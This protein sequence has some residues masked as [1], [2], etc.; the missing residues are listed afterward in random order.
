MLTM[1]PVVI[2]ISLIGNIDPNS[3]TDVIFRHG[4]WVA[5]PFEAIGLMA[6][7]CGSDW[8]E[9]YDQMVRP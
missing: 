4:S 8:R 9:N 2:V 1:I 5:V 6:V 3:V 7:I